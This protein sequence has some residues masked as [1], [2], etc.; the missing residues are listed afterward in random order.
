MSRRLLFLFGACP[1]QKRYLVEFRF[2]SGFGR[3]VWLGGRSD[4][5]SMFAIASWLGHDRS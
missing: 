5:G 4:G 1:Y 3:R 2:D